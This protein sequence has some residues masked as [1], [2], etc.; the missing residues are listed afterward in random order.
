[1]SNSFCHPSCRKQ[2]PMI[3]VCNDWTSFLPKR[4]DT[5]LL[6][7]IRNGLG[8]FV[9][10]KPHH[11]LRVEPPWL[12]LQG[13]GCQILGLSALQRKKWTAEV[14]IEEFK[15]VWTRQIR[16]V[17]N[18]KLDIVVSNWPP[19]S[20]RWR[21][22]FLWRASGKTLQCRSVAVAPGGGKAGWGTGSSS[23]TACNVH[24]EGG[25]GVKWDLTRESIKLDLRWGASTN[26]AK[27]NL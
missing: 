2:N 19:G 18:T 14:T 17:T 7:L 3:Q 22:A 1:M 5:D 27:W 23:G 16:C 8:F 6:K 26:D 21:R 4:R 10:L 25:R 11:V 9:P 24:T 20:K 15:S 13:F 12:L